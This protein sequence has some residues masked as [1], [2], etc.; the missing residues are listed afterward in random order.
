MIVYDTCSWEDFKTRQKVIGELQTCYLLTINR[1][2]LF[3][4]NIVMV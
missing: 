2:K 3:V 1:K 4:S